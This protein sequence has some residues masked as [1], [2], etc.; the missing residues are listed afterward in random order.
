MKRALKREIWGRSLHIDSIFLQCGRGSAPLWSVGAWFWCPVRAPAAWVAVSVPT[1]RAVGSALEQTWGALE[2]CCWLQGLLAHLQF[3]W[4]SSS[5]LINLFCGVTE[6]SEFSYLQIWG[7]AN[8]VWGRDRF[9]EAELNIA[10]ITSVFRV[11]DFPC[12][13]EFRFHAILC[14]PTDGN[15]GQRQ[16]QTTLLGSSWCRKGA[17][18]L[19]KHLIRKPF[20]PRKPPIGWGAIPSTS[21][22]PALASTKH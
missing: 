4:T 18:L 22:V 11:Y 10:S 20:A 16:A 12:R 3:L 21:A 13:S 7:L 14:A 19:C 17:A 5:P 1:A 6:Y 2:H 15:G 9:L 8:S